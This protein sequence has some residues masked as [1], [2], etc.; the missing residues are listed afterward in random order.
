MKNETKEFLKK[1]WLAKKFR[2]RLNRRKNISYSQC[3]EDLI[4]KF[5]LP[6]KKTDFMLISAPMIRYI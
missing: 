2:E 6:N 1:F 3:G 5:F 4:A